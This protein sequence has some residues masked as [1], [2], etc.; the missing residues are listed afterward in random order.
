MLPN[1]QHQ[2]TEGKNHCKI[3]IGS[4]FLVLPFW[5]Q[6]TQV[7]PDRIQESRKTVVRAC[8]F[9]VP[10]H[11]GGPEQRAV[12]RVSVIETCGADV[13]SLEAVRQQ[14]VEPGGA[15]RR[16][17]RVERPLAAGQGLGEL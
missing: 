6:L 15:L 4:T 11:P 12:K 7:V 16:D 1:H 9:L 10:A 14:G 8:T 5:Y 13:F 3:Q 17:L 2:S